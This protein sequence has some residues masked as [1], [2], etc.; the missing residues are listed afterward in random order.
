MRTK[1][2][3]LQAINT[4]NIFEL[5]SVLHSESIIRFDNTFFSSGN[6]LLQQLQIFYNK[7]LITGKNVI[8][9]FKLQNHHGWTFIDFIAEQQD[10]Q[11]INI[12]FAFL[13]ELIQHNAVTEK[14]ILDLLKLQTDIAVTFPSIIASSLFSKNVEM[15]LTFFTDLTNTSNVTAKDILDLLKLQ[16]IDGST[17]FDFVAKYQNSQITQKLLIFLQNLIDNPS[18]TGKNLFEILKLQNNN[19]WTFISV[20]ARYQ[21]AQTIQMLLAFLRKLVNTSHI[22]TKDIFNLI[23]LPN[24]N[25]WAFIHHVARYQDTQTLETL[26]TFLQ[27]LTD[28]TDITA[29]NIL[30]LLKTKNNDDWNFIDIETNRL[31]ILISQTLDKMND[32]Y[33]FNFAKNILKLLNHSNYKPVTSCHSVAK[34][35]DA[36]TTQTLLAHLNDLYNCFKLLLLPNG[37]DWPPLLTLSIVST[38]IGPRLRDYE[39]D[40]NLKILTNCL[41]RLCEDPAVANQKTLLKW[42]ANNTENSA[43]QFQLYQF[44]KTKNRSKATQ[45][46]IKAKNNQNLNALLEEVVSTSHTSSSFFQK[47]NPWGLENRTLYAV[48]YN[49]NN[50]EKLNLLNEIIYQARVKKY[51]TVEQSIECLQKMLKQNSRFT[52]IELCTTLVLLAEQYVIKGDSNASKLLDKIPVDKPTLTGEYHLYVSELY[53]TKFND[54]EKAEQHYTLA[55]QLGIAEDSCFETVLGQRWS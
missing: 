22:S 7:K 14:D 31:N 40:A 29:A 4:N 20:V 32:L 54:K 42:Y 17:F 41:N 9:L 6:T 48:N 30:D 43:A 35:N 1:E 16:T 36:Q 18:V 46:F 45:Y 3:L 27:D 39:A 52:S 23:K 34:Y 33:N 15:L 38:T 25:N 28:N 37:K 8:E 26:L 55:K 53:S 19:G 10:E 5:S 24:Q 50:S 12:L 49:T 21:D 11:E 13:K 47:Y 44:Y 51:I 2:R